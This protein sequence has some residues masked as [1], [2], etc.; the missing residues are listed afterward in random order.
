MSSGRAVALDGAAVLSV[1]LAACLA[2][3]DTP[4]MT[5]MVAGAWI[6]R[7]ALWSRLPRAE[8]PLEM[9]RE[10]A[11]MVLCAAVGGLNDWNTVVRHGVYA[12][13]VPSDL[14]WSSIPAWMF[15]YWGL[16]L[17]FV[18]SLGLWP[19]L[20]DPGPRGAVRG[21]AG[22]RPT[23]RLALLL[24]LV[25]VTRQC[26]YRCSTDPWLSWL[27]FAVAL[28]LHP[29]LFPWGRRQ[30]RLASLAAVVGPLA[31]AALIGVGGLH[32]YALGWILGVPLWIALWWILATL[33]WT[34]LSLDLLVWLAPGAGRPTLTSVLADTQRGQLQ[35]RVRP[36]GA[37]S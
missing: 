26:I 36:G 2:A 25:L 31:E 4:F 15:A 19:A 34:E 22:Q 7:A 14:S 27:P 30:L 1:G 23:M 35:R 24:V 6:V 29:L 5:A 20:G 3:R 32:R 8:R 37:P 28:G 18:T 33:V 9:P 12:Y 21:V 11:F 13:G 10:M 17:R 16:I